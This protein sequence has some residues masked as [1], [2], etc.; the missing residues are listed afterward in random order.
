MI[1]DTIFLI[2][3][4]LI[5][6]IVLIL[7]LIKTCSNNHNESWFVIYSRKC[8]VLLCMR[9]SSTFYF[10]GGKLLELK[11]RKLKLGRSYVRSLSAAICVP[12]K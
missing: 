11:T 4:A 6:F 3:I 5:F 1:H 8:G 9:C 7:I 10:V 2:L 12:G